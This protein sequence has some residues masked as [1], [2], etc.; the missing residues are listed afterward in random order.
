[1]QKQVITPKSLPDP[2]AMWS[3]G[4]LC[5]GPGNTLFISGVSSRDAS[6]NLV[7]EGDL[8]GQTHQVCENLKSIV[9][10]AGATLADVVSMTTYVVDVEQVAT[11]HRVRRAY[12]PKDPPASAMVQVPRLVDRRCLIEISAIAAFD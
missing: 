2:K 11:I 7:A 6:G 12:F 4:I 8:E 9:E 1:M 10:A 5:R 3:P